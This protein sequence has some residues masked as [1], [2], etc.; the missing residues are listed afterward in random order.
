VGLSLKK[1]FL[2]WRNYAG[3]W[4]KSRYL[5]RYCDQKDRAE[6]AQVRMIL[7][8]RGWNEMTVGH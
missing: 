7:Y 1:R 6:L 3:G 2:R 8:L 5:P 4:V